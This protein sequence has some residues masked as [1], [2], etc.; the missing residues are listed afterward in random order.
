[1]KVSKAE[2]AKQKLEKEERR[3]AREQK[4]IELELKKQAREKRK[5]ELEKKRKEKEEAKNKKEVYKKSA[6][7]I[8][9]FIKKLPIADGDVKPVPMTKTEYDLIK[10]ILSYEY[11]KPSLMSQTFNKHSFRQIEVKGDEIVLDV[12]DVFYFY[13]KKTEKG[14]N[15]G[16]VTGSWLDTTKKVPWNF[17]V[18]IVE[19]EKK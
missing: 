19:V 16:P 3:K 4:K 13:N 10:K 6:A 15:F 12:D 14:I 11:Y 5:I 7:E 1:M 8:E 17:K 2:I 9:N 18:N